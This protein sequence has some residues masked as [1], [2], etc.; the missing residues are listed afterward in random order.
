LCQGLDYAFLAVPEELLTVTQYEY[1]CIQEK[2]RFHLP[3]LFSI[4]LLALISSLLLMIIY[5]HD[6]L[7]S[8][9]LYGI[10]ILHSSSILAS[11]GDNIEICKSETIV[12]AGNLNNGSAFDTL[13]TCWHLHHRQLHIK[14][15]REQ[16]ETCTLFSLGLYSLH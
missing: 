12:V 7:S 10:I 6:I 1:P 13:S 2:W 9:S 3:E 5:L 8:E 16:K 14:M 11:N 15:Q 4:K